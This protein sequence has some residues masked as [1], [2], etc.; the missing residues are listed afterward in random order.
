MSLADLERE[1]KESAGAVLCDPRVIRRVIKHH[2]NVNGLVPHGRCYGIERQALAE[3]ASAD[4]LGVA[5]AE[6]PEEVMLVARPSPREV[7]ARL[8]AETATRLWRNIFHARIHLALQKRVSRGELDD[9]NVR[10]RIALI[11]QTEFDEIRAILRHDDLVMPPGDD[12]EVY[13][14]FA[15]L[16]LELKHFAPALLLTTFPGVSDHDRVREALS[17]DVDVIPLLERGR[18]ASVASPSTTRQLAQTSMPSFSAPA[19]FANEP[20]KAKPISPKAHQKLLAKARAAREQGNDV[21]AAL[22]CSQAALIGDKELSREAQALGRDALVHLGGRLTKALASPEVK[23]RARDWSLLLILGARAAEERAVRYSVEARLLYTLQRAAIAFEE[24]HTAVELA[25]WLSSFGKRK[26]VRELPATREL[27]VAR[28]IHVAAKRVRNVRIGD[29][30]RKLCARLMSWASERAEA[31]VRA[32]LR[33]R[34]TGVFDEVG[35]TA[36]SGPELLARRKVTEE[37]IDFIL[38][39]GY[40]SFDALRDALSR[41]Q[42]KLDDLARPRELWA[43]DPLLHADAAL[44]VALDGIY[45]RGDIYLRGLQKVSSLPFGT[46]IGRALALYFILP[47]GASYVVLDALNH[48]VNPALGWFGKQPVELRNLT[49]FLATS[50]V[51]FALIH[52]APFRGFAKQLLELL[53]RIFATVFFR[54]PRTVL[55]SAVFRRFFA[56]PTVRF[57]LRRVLFPAAIGVGAYYLVPLAQWY[58]KAGIAAAII[59][60]TSVVMGSRLGALFEDFVV[61]QLA[62]TWQVI[63][64]QW[65]PGLLR[66]ISRFFAA[67]MDLMQRSFVRVDELLRFRRGEN[68]IM[69]VVKGAAGFVWAIISY[70]IRLYV[71]LLVEPEINPLKHVPVVTVAHKVMLPYLDVLWEL[72]KDRL[73]VLGPVIGTTFAGVTVFLLPSVFGFFAWELKE[74]YKLYRATRPDRLPPS[75][76]GPHGATMR[77]LLVVGLHSGTLPKLYERLRRAAQREDEAA[78]ISFRSPASR[79][80]NLGGLGRFR[81]G[82]REI[83]QGVRRFVEREL[84][85]V[86]HRS[87]RWSFGR[88]SVAGVDLSSNRIR[89]TISCSSMKDRVAEITFE[90]Q[91]GYLVAGAA[92]PGF[93]AQL[94]QSSPEQALLFENALA[95]L[96]QLAEVDLVREQIVA[97][98]GET[99]H[100]DIADDGLVVWPQK[101]YRTELIYPIHNEH[102]RVIEPRVRGAEP[103]LPPPVLDTRRMSFSDQ[104]ISWLAWVA[105]WTAAERADARIPRLLRGVSILPSEDPTSYAPT[106]VPRPFVSMPATVPAT[107]IIAAQ[108]ERT[109]EMTHAMKTPASPAVTQPM[110]ASTSETVKE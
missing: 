13:I 88:L 101:D 98:L 31:N 39:R 97:E 27:R 24:P 26:I 30:D 72:S 55:T 64:R 65:L 12:R 84:I 75:P 51:A 44:A 70:V 92:Q 38:D 96:Y 108:V 25:T 42:L 87:P 34:I 63:S 86:L 3:L 71:T 20:A 59:V 16:Y 18:P 83:E 56:R 110:G 45:R 77:S 74:N 93:M 14:E 47:F 37:L 48:F 35:L 41:N 60:A 53:T 54:V 94:V 81:D 57:A 107:P 69:L 33:P 78:V 85:A 21:R 80:S 67:M 73:A 62:P 4:E 22:L 32:A 6:L 9:A 36:V 1:L 40:L 105:A 95:G 90:E 89:I 79:G 28:L 46:A 50:A 106:P 109:L 91:S 52:S 66:L 102:G 61:D 2:R 19:A 17:Q 103:D 5:L 76:V 11:G 29:A 104:A 82:L 15:A 68:A 49:S 58:G 8:R 43:G 23:D 10:Q 7:G 99:A 100:Y